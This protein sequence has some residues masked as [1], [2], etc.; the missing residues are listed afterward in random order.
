M[1]G[2]VRQRAERLL[3]SMGKTTGAYS[4]SQGVSIILQDVAK[5][6][7]QRYLF[8]YLFFVLINVKT[9]EMDTP[10]TQTTFF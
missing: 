5:F 9:P 2:D 4:N 7:E 6:I 10:V 1:P 8:I 3:T